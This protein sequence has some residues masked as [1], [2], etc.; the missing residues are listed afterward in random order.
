VVTKELLKQDVL[1]V[2]T[3]CSA[4]ANAK[5][6]LLM[7]QAGLDQVGPGLREIC[8]ATGMPPVLHM[9]S[10]VDNTRI[11]TVLTQVVEEGGLGDD[12]DQVPAVGLAPEWMS[13]K[14]LAIGTY[15]VASGAYVIFGGASPV[16][17]MPDKVEDS[18]IVTNIMSE[19]W[20]E[21][22]GGKM[23]FIPDPQDMIQATLDHIDKKREELGLV[24]YDPA[25]FGKSGD[26]DMLELEKLPLT[27]RRQAIYGSAGK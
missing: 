22:F 21:Q 10:C 3:G 27:E 2:E 6:G 18:T 9:G 15:C 12:I 11:L 13:E 4:I 26:K 7:G 5:Q 23:E 19:G 14:A 8:E 16:G 25:M 20:E 1:V 17:G 24:K